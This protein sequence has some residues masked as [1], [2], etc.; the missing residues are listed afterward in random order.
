MHTLDDLVKPEKIVNPNNP[1]YFLS[2]AA[3][4]IP[5]MEKAKYRWHI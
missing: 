2:A 4:E 3:M 1:M 5:A